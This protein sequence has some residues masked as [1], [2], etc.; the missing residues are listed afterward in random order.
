[1]AA[2]GTSVISSQQARKLVTSR[3]VMTPTS[4]ATN[5]AV[6]AATTRAAAPLN[7]DPAYPPPRPLRW[8]GST[9]RSSP[10]SYGVAGEAAPVKLHVL[11]GLGIGDSPIE[12][13]LVIGI[14]QKR[15]LTNTAPTPTAGSLPAGRRS[16]AADPPEA[17]TPIPARSRSGR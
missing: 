7:R 5:A 13:S 9:A 14:C 8:A 4:A 10:P 11:L 17:A 2:A 15:P 1:M 16:T 3:A 6:S 12:S